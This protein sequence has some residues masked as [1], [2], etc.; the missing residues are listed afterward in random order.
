MLDWYDL[1]EFYIDKEDMD[2]IFEEWEMIPSED[3][4]EEMYQ[5]YCKLHRDLQDS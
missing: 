5:E 1:I 3:E 2:D 4:I